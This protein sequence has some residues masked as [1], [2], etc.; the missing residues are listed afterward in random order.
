[1]EKILP[2]SKVQT[3]IHNL[4]KEIAHGG[5]PVIITQKSRADVIML[6]REEYENLIATI[7]VLSSE[8]LMNSLR[9]SLEDLRKKEIISLKELQRKMSAE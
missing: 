1:M 7:E 2:V 6:N 8:E 3:K 9:K 5:N 4:V